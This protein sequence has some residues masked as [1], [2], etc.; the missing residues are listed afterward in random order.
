MF[1]NANISSMGYLWSQST[2]FDILKFILGCEAWGNK[3]KEMILRL[4]NEYKKHFF[5]LIPPSLAAKYEF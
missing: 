5:C 4:S 2:K 3:T 1:A